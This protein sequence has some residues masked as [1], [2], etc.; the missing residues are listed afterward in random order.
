MEYNRN[1]TFE[2]MIMLEIVL[3]MIVHI[4]SLY[5]SICSKYSN[6]S[7]YTCAF[8]HIYMCVDAY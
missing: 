2:C 7:V 5:A 4:T 1:K 8:I 3:H 6:V